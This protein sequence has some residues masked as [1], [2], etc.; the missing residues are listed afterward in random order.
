MKDLKFLKLLNVLMAVPSVNVKLDCIPLLLASITSL[1]LKTQVFPQP[2]LYAGPPCNS[3]DDSV[4]RLGNFLSELTLGI[5]WSNTNIN[6]GKV[7][8]EAHKKFGSHNTSPHYCRSGCASAPG[9]AECCWLCGATV[10][11]LT[12][13]VE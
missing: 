13:R 11:A 7:E 10:K 12:G 3:V 5:G 6:C 9:V 2:F 4:L 1:H 8:M